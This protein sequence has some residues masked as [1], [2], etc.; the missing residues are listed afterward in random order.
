MSDDL[1]FD[2]GVLLGSTN[3]AIWSEN[4]AKHPG[5]RVMRLYYTKAGKTEN[6]T[7]RQ[8]MQARFGRA[9]REKVELMIETMAPYDGRPIAEIEEA[10]ANFLI[11][12]IVASGARNPS[13][14]NGLLAALASESPIR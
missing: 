7:A 8:M 5:A 14:L 10:Y 9:P 1:P 3:E 12:E 4:A 2:I 6:K 13:S 11:G